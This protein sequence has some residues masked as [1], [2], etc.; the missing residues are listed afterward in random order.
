MK[1]NGRDEPEVRLESRGLS[2]K[3][4]GLRMRIY[5]FETFFLLKLFSKKKKKEKK[6]SKK[7]KKVSRSGDEEKWQG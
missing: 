4:R 7:K 1:K 2:R 3:V 6:F 5:I